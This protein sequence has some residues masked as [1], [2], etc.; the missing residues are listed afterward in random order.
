MYHFKSVN[1]AYEKSR[2]LCEIGEKAIVP[3]YVTFELTNWCNFNCRMCF[4]SYIKKER[5]DIVPELLK[6]ALDE[7]SSWGS[8]IRF[9]G[10]EEPF[11]YFHIEKAIEMVKKKNLLLHITTNGS[12]MNERIIDLLVNFQVDSI[13]V[14]FQGLSESEYLTMRN[15]TRKTYEN[16]KKNIKMLFNKR[17]DDKPFIKITTTITERDDSSSY[18]Q[19]AKDLLDYADEVQITG[20]THFIHIDESFKNVNINQKLNL[21]KPHL[22]NDINC[23]VP[24]FEM[25]IR[26]NGDVLPCSGA[27][28]DDLIIGNLQEN[29]LIQIWNSEKAEVIRDR[30]LHNHLS[31]FGDCNVCPI[32]YSYPD[33]GNSLS[34]VLERRLIILR[35]N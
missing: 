10:Y 22:L 32:R 28:T 26:A 21:S 2:E 30:L 12:L 23:I 4:R 31:D 5:N 15:S 16:V 35:K 9:L 17:R 13:I 33:H 20:Y 1:E 7:I 8:M 3:P 27:L 18:E 14:S 11:S 6:K 34:N 19:F 29:R 24:N 25:L